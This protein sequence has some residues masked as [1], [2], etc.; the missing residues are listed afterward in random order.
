VAHEYLETHRD[1][2]AAVFAQAQRAI[3]N[4]DLDALTAQLNLGPEAFTDPVMAR[5]PVGR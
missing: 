2:L 5:L 4:G 3:A 1:R